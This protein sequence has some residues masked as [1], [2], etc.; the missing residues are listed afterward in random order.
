M[1]IF[2]CAMFALNISSPINYVIKLKGKVLGKCQGD[3][4]G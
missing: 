3:K 2:K 1:Q 4:E